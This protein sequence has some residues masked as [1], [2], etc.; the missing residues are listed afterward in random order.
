MIYNSAAGDP[1]FVSWSGGKDA[2]LSFLKAKEY[3][4]K[5]VSLLSFVGDDGHSRSHGLK[6]ALLH[7]QA[8]A[9]GLP[10]QSEEVSWESYESGFERAVGLLRERYGITGGVFGDIN[11]EEHRQWIEKMAER[12]SIDY[13]LPLWLMEERLVSAELIRRGGRAMIV[14]IRNDLVDLKWLGRFMDQEYI[15]YC[16]S[17]GISPC[18][19]GGETQTFVVDGPL[20][21]GPLDYQTGSIIQQENCSRL[22]LSTAQKNRPPVLT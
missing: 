14:A 21:A 22:E 3:G 12:C 19:E 1:V 18:G 6:T 5:V 15:D 9:L 16:L 17:A 2:Y 7:E 20:F 10:L 13:N 8:K 11:L 4:L